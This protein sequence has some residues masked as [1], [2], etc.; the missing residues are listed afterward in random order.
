MDAERLGFLLDR[1]VDGELAPDEK[2]ELER[3][4]LSSPEA[5]AVFW[6]KARFHA[7]L[8]QYGEQTWGK[9]AGAEKIV[10][11]P[12]RRAAWLAAAAGLLIGGLA[13]AWRISQ[14]AEEPTTDGVAMLGQTV[15]AVW[16]DGVPRVA[17]AVLPRGWLRLQSGLAQVEFVSGARVILEGPA[18]LQLTAP[19]TAFC[20]RGRLTAEVPAQA[21]GFRVDSPQASV[22]D[23]GTEFGMD[24][25][26]DGA[27]DVHV[28]RGS[29]EVRGGADRHTL[30]EGESLHVTAAGA[31]ADFSEA[32]PVFPTGE[33]LEVRAAN[34]L[35]ARHLNWRAAARQIAAMPGLVLCFDFQSGAPWART[36][37]N[38]TEDAER[39]PAGSIVG[40]RWSEG[41]WPGKQALEFRT[42]TD[43][44]RLSAP[45]E[46]PSFTFA[47]WVRIDSLDR[48][49]NSLIMGDGWG[50]GD[51]HWQISK[52]GE[53]ILGLFGGKNVTSAPVFPPERL[54]QWTHLAVTFD[55]STGRV[56]HYLDGLPI[57]EGAA[58]P[59]TIA[60]MRLDHAEIGNWNQS[61]RDAQPIRNFNGRMD[62]VLVFRRGLRAEELQALYRAGQPAER[63]IAQAANPPGR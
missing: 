10:R 26:A 31:L 25:H 45:G 47:A 57:A 41:R 60:A 2:T 42:V 21:L 16:S 59:A 30:S 33:Q 43:R 39:G 6:E 1:Y 63:V 62:E 14:P 27:T 58:P 17:G 51:A 9:G 19:L 18:E 53:L 5:R 50:S 38:I 56:I 37:P 61:S 32:A 29:V 22:V 3:M 23:L 55:R 11:F 8:R 20:K 24:V 28:F 4:L 35:R 7:L 34:G 12:I 48:A 13:L 54:A 52:A 49:Y 46:F 44:V 36:L 40:C 15:D